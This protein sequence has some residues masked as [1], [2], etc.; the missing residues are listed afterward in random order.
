MDDND[1]DKLNYKKINIQLN[2]TYTNTSSIEW[3]V[4]VFKKGNPKDYIKWKLCC[5]ELEIA[6]PLDS[7]LKRLNMVQNLV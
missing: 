1:K 6:I 7:A 5:K 4:Q 3:K 2:Y